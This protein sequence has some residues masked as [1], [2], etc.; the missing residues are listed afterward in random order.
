MYREI[1]NLELKKKKMEVIDEETKTQE[2]K[3]TLLKMC[4]I[5]CNI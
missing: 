3:V 2:N 5:N 4:A 1:I